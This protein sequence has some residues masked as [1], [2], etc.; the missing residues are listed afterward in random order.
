MMEVK[1]TLLSG[2]MFP[3]V[4]THGSTLFYLMWMVGGDG[5]WRIRDGK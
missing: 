2:H 4:A 5:S 3:E 1:Q